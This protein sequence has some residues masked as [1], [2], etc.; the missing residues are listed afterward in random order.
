MIERLAK[1]VEEAESIAVLTGAGI[2][3][4]SGIPDFRSASGIYSDERNV[5]VFDLDAFMR[6]PHI[7]YSFARAFYPQVCA[8]QPNAAHLALAAWQRRGKD[9]TVITQNVDDYHQ[10]AGSDP[11]FTVHGNY[12]HSTCQTCGARVETEILFPTIERGEI[13]HCSCGGI[14]KPDITFFGEMLPEHDWNASVRAIATADLMLVLGTSLAVYPAAALPKYRSPQAR[15]AIV[16]HDPTPLDTDAE[17]VIHADICS[18]MAA[19]TRLW[20][21]T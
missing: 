1:W 3:T 15:L 9:M 12:I 19:V 17:C 6:D 21:S 18:V 8:A 10:R 2:S 4:A 13:P 20:I 16:N 5:N 7:F 11:V 14:F